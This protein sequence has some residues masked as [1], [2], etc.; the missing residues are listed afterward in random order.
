MSTWHG[1][2]ST[3]IPALSCALEQGEINLCPKGNS[4]FTIS[5]QYALAR[6]ISTSSVIYVL[7]FVC[8]TTLLAERKIYGR[9]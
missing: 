6:F 9:L 1:N 8:F 3:W 2:G 7:L 4:A 5:H